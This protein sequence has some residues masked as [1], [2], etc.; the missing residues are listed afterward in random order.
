MASM[1]FH[2]NAKYHHCP[3]SSLPFAFPLDWPYQIRAATPITIALMPGGGSM[4]EG[5]LRVTLFDAATRAPLAERLVF[6]EPAH[7]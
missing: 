1:A 3:P 6:R 2:E 4:G 5:V 7:R